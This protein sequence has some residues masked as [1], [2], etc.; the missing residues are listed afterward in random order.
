MLLAGEIC[1]QVT[2]QQSHRYSS[3]SLGGAE[4]LVQ[5]IR[6]SMKAFKLQVE[7]GIGKPLKRGM[8]ILHWLPRHAAWVYNR[9]HIRADTRLTPYEKVNYSKHQRPILMFGEAVLCK[10]PGA[11]LNKLEARW[12]EGVWPFGQPPF[13]LL[14]EDH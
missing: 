9:F 11:V 14:A 1:L 6:N 5:T 13:P 3:Q 8:A 12:L 2:Q 7:K 4:R 10:R